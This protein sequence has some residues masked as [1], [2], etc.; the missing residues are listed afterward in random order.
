MEITSSSDAA[1]AAVAAAAEAEAAIAEA[2]ARY[3]GVWHECL[4]SNMFVGSHALL[5]LKLAYVRSNSI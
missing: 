3:S 1:K 5:G 2:T 4:C